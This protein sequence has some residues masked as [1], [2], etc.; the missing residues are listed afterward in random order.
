MASK[1][2]NDLTFWNCPAKK[3]AKAEEFKSN[4]STI[5]SAAGGQSV[6]AQ[7]SDH[8]AVSSMSLRSIKSSHP[9][10]SHQTLVSQQTS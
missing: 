1:F 2:H 5:S 9:W 3:L 6:K 4:F 8:K 10:E 7:N